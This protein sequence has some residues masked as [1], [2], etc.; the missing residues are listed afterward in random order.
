MSKRI[1][2][3][4]RDPRVPKLMKVAEEF[5]AM[6]DTM[7]Q[8]C[9]DTDNRVEEVEKKVGGER[10][11]VLGGGRTD[12]CVCVCWGGR[13]NVCMGG[14]GLC[15][16]VCV[17]GGEGQCVCGVGLICVCVR[18]VSMCVCWG[19][20]SMCVGGEGSVTRE[21]GRV[22][23]GGQEGIPRHDILPFPST[24]NPKGSVG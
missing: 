15:V 4:E 16:F 6:R 23:G 24:P 20:G 22:E 1:E 9:T 18:G 10:V 3:L 19:G 2:V 11:N 21:G 13:V 17:L 5:L 7:K 14:E 12:L 8:Y